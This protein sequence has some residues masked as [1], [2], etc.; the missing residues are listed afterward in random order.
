MAF[1]FKKLF[2][3]NFNF[4]TSDLGVDLGTANVLIYVEGK[5]VVVR[6][7]SVVAVDKNTG[8][9]LQVGADARNMMGRTPGN[10]VAMRPLKDGV[11]SDHEMTVEMLKELF[12]KAIKSSI[13]NPKPRV[14]ICVPS[15]VTEVEERS[16]INAAI[17]AGARRVYLIEEPLAAALGANLPIEEANGHMVVDVGGG[18]TD[19]AVLSLNGVARSSSVEAAGDA[20]DEAIARHVR[21]KHGVVIGQVTAEE[22]KIQIGCVW[23]RPED[24]T[25]SV[26]GRDAKTGLPREI[27][28]YSSE[29]YEVLRRPARMITDEVLHVLEETSPELVGDIALNGITLTGGGSQIWGMDQLIHERTG[30]PCHLADDP[31]SCVVYGCG[32]SISWINEKLSEGPINLARKRIMRE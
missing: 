32:R 2:N 24:I 28:L 17:E 15:G 7:P 8:K 13:F 21:R 30:I 19:V 1:N 4:F 11:I 10:V 9:I 26:K 29:I 18:T 25:M 14:V 22:I 20:F 5:G 31:D 6:E 27:L 3:F 23:P 16:V 12:R